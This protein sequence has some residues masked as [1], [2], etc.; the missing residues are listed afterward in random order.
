MD[1]LAPELIDSVAFIAPPNP[2]APVPTPEPPQPAAIS[3]RIADIPDGRI[4]QCD[5]GEIIFK[6]LLL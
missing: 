1:K 2:G 5:P 6:E 4:N 3:T